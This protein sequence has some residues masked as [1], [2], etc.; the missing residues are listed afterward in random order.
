MNFNSSD[1]FMLNPTQRF[2]ALF[3]N[4]DLL[5]DFLSK[6]EGQIPSSD[7]KF[8][9]G[10]TGRK[11]L[12]AKGEDHGLWG[13]MIRGFQN[14]LEVQKNYVHYVDQQL[15]QGAYAVSVPSD[16]HQEEM[17]QRLQDAGAHFIVYF[18][19]GALV[20]YSVPAEIQQ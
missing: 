5:Q 20:D 15:Q 3:E 10:E 1:D 19:R 9:H 11:I 14:I 2:I 7:I 8:L 13:K 16:K 12:D 6:I 18:G 4:Y 17:A